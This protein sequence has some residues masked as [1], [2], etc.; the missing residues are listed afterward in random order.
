MAEYRARCHC[1]ALALSFRTE[2][3]PERWPKRVCPCSFCRAR[4][5]VH[6]SDPAGSLAIRL[7]AGAALIRYRFGT[8]TADFLICGTCGGYLGATTEGASGP[9]GVLNLRALETPID[10]EGAVPLEAEGEGGD[11]R[12]ARRARNWTPVVP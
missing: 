12:T 4:G 11:A 10:L 1:G 2:R 7:A 9:L 6:T 5:A 3:P 8:R